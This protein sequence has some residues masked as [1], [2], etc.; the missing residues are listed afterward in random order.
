MTQLRDVLKACDYAALSRVQPHKVVIQNLPCPMIDHQGQSKSKGP[1][2]IIHANRAYEG[3]PQSSKDE[4]THGTWL[5]Q[6]CQREGNASDLA[7]LLNLAFPA[8][9]AAGHGCSSV[10][11]FIGWRVATSSQGRCIGSSSQGGLFC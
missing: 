5:C 8:D 4:Y 2:A 10:S 7:E 6:D 11:V 3:S 9:M 1:F